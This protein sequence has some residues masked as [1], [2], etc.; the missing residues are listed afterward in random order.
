MRGYKPYCIFNYCK[1]HVHAHSLCIT[2]TSQ[3]KK[4]RIRN[5]VCTV[6]QFNQ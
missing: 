6:F 4:P 1:L 3:S 5:L 2:Y